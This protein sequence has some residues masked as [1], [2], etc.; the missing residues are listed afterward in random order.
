MKVEDHFGIEM[1]AE[2]ASNA[3]T[4]ADLQQVIVDRLVE[5]GRPPSSD[6]H[7][8]VFQELVR[9]SVEIT[10]NGPATIRPESRWVGKVTEYG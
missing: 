1:P 5:Q 10:G 4:V 8:E 6:L 9:I 3:V 2:V 7:A